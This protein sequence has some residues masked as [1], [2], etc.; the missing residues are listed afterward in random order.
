MSL[1][2][3][4]SPKQQV[5]SPSISGSE[6]LREVFLDPEKKAAFVEEA[7]SKMDLLEEEIRRAESMR[8]EL[9]KL[10]YCS[11]DGK[12]QDGELEELF[13]DFRHSRQHK[14]AEITQARNQLA[15]FEKHGMFIEDYATHL[16]AL[17]LR[18]VFE[19]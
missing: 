3:S 5:L 8:L 12:L 13:D 1:A 14:M 2:D 11:S 9:L 15:C 6:F 16:R 18:P 17:L 7:D 4:K 10:G 19:D